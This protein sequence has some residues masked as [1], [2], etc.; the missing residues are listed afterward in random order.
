MT[1]VRLVE[2]FL[3]FQVGAV[4]SLAS[5][6]PPRFDTFSEKVTGRWHAIASTNNVV[7]QQ[8]AEEVMRSCGGAVQG[9]R[10]VPLMGKEDSV[11]EGPYLNRADDGFTFFDCGSYTQGPV[12]MEESNAMTFLASLSVPSKPASRI[13]LETEIE[14]QAVIA[15]RVHTRLQRAAF[16]EDGSSS[17]EA[18][19]L[20]VEQLK[21]PPHDI[22][23]NQQFQCRMPSESQPWMMQRVQWEMFEDTALASPTDAD[24]RTRSWATIQDAADFNDLSNNG[25]S[26][27]SNGWVV[28]MGAQCSS[29]GWAKSI[30]RHYD[31]KGMLIRVA[32]QQVH[33]DGS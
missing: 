4:H 22:A 5:C 27:N 16:G 18:S 2:A 24:P 17:I 8:T 19:N 11:E 30:V 10:D 28:C 23:F 26:N 31:E 14:N 32:M 1:I 25:N 33:L 20:V 12:R 7:T 29:T 3:L 15:C 21:A 9:V 6:A 13:V